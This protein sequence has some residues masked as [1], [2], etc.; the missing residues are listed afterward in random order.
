MQTYCLSTSIF[1]MAFLTFSLM[2][3]YCIW[4]TT[5]DSST[6]LSPTSYPFISSWKY[7]FHLPNTVSSIVNTFPSVSF[8]RFFMLLI[9]SVCQFVW[10]NRYRPFSHY[11]L[12]SVLHNALYVCLSP[13][14]A[15]HHFTL[16]L[17]C[18]IFLSVL[19]F[20]YCSLYFIPPPTLLILL[21]Q[22]RCHIMCL[23]CFLPNQLQGVWY[24]PIWLPLPSMSGTHTSSVS[25][26]IFFLDWFP[27]GNPRF[28]PHLPPLLSFQ[29][30]LT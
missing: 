20:S 25:F 24:L 23:L 21:F 3:T 4:L 9:L 8:F 19:V 2:I 7:L 28:S 12:S 1:P 18:F 14:Q 26:T 27:T 13:S 6:L 29:I 10:Q 22:S 17:V 30:H 15:V 11:L 5:L 16:R